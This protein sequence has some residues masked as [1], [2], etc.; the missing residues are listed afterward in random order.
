MMAMTVW[1][2]VCVAATSAIATPINI[3]AS[4]YRT[5]VLSLN[6]ALLAIM[7]NDGLQIKFTMPLIEGARAALYG[8]IPSLRHLFVMCIMYPMQPK[9]VQNVDKTYS[10]KPVFFNI[11]KSIKDLI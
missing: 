11:V 5:P 8:S 4:P 6:G 9:V 2:K 7:P 1:M 10:K 3:P